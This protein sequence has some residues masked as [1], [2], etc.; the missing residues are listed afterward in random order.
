M[1]KLK[2]NCKIETSA[3]NHARRCKF[4][5]SK[6]AI[7]KKLGENLVQ[8]DPKLNLVQATNMSVALWFSELRTI[9]VGQQLKFTQS[10]ESSGVDR[11]IMLR[12]LYNLCRIP[13]NILESQTEFQYYPQL[14]ELGLLCY[15]LE[16]CFLHDPDSCFLPLRVFY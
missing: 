12:L 9:G 15:A 14:T 16:R 10:L 1:P 2:Y 3:K 4:E 11:I 8:L 6:K 13:F 5:H 7:D